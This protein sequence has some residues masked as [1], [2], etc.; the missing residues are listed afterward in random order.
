MSICNQLVIA[1]GGIFGFELNPIGPKFT[2][3]VPLEHMNSKLSGT[4]EDQVILDSS[5]KDI[6]VT[7]AATASGSDAKVPVKVEGQLYG[8]IVDDIKTNRQLLG[9]LVSNRGLIIDTAEDGLKAVD[10]IKE[11]GEN[12]NIIFMDNMMPNMTGIES[13]AACRK[14][15]YGGLIIGV[16]GNTLGEEVTAFL[17][18]GADIIL[19]K[20]VNGAQLDAIINH[21][22]THGKYSPK[23]IVHESR[24]DAELKEKFETLTND[25]KKKGD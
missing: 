11:K 12:I 22:R 24:N 15:G 20:P 3:L 9:R 7:V 10:Y 14:L 4:A 8:L 13:T 6:A 25:V 1:H 2:F 18:A 5:K 19:G 16:T 23:S 21:I 17:D